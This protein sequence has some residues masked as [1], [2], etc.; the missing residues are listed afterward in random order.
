M[1]V[2]YGTTLEIR[3]PKIITSEI[4]RDFGFAFYTTA[5]KEQA[6]RWARR[7]AKIQSRLNRNV[8]A[9]VNVY[10]WSRSD[11]LRVKEF[12]GAS[13]D[14]LETV[15]NCRSNPAFR[16]GF[17]VAIGNIAD[18]DVGETVAF[19]VQGIMR[20]EDAIKRLQFKK[21]NDQI[22]FCTEK[23]L[24]EIDFVESYVLES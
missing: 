4:G 1:L 10:E 6:E 22:A 9:I 11:N 23:A 16:H 5:Q 12:D 20:K 19:V 15:V 7:R 24:S 3:E 17:D 21:I 8:P 2:Y 18:D 14:W 13:L